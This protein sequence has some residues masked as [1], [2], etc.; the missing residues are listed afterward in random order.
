MQCARYRLPVL[1]IFHQDSAAETVFSVYRYG[2]AEEAEQRDRLSPGAQGQE[3]DDADCVSARRQPGASLLRYVCSTTL[4]KITSK[5][6][7]QCPGMQMNEVLDSDVHE[8]SEK[9]SSQAQQRLERS[10]LASERGTLYSLGLSRVPGGCFPQMQNYA[11]WM[12]APKSSALFD[13][14][15][16]QHSELSAST[17]SFSCSFVL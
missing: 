8:S 13:T 10:P 6:R 11:E 7:S 16:T 12:Q 9:F 1:H 17:D 14:R 5:S 4:P 2:E 15:V 3:C